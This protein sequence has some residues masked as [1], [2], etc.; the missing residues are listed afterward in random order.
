M[1]EVTL[2][3]QMSIAFD[4][5][6]SEQLSHDELERAVKRIVASWSDGRR[7]LPVELAQLG[8]A[9]VLKEAIRYLGYPLIFIAGDRDPTASLREETLEEFEGRITTEGDSTP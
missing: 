6:S 5:G 9:E 1:R 2:T 7:P 3:L 4:I 8:G